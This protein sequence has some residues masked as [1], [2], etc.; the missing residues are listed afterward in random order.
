MF[1]VSSDRIFNVDETGVCTVLDQPCVF[2]EKG[3]KQVG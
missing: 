3:T 2:A 1:P